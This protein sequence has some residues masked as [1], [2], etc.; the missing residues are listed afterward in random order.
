[1]HKEIHVIP[2]I[3]M[4]H[5]FLPLNK[6]K[7]KEIKAINHFLKEIKKKKKKEEKYTA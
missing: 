7:K 4:Q 1:M 3:I 6:L 5:N 2:G